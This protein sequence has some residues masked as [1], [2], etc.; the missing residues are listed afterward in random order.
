MENKVHLGRL[1]KP[2]D[3]AQRDA[4]HLAVAPVVAAIRLS[5][6]QR[7]SL[8]VDGKAAPCDRPIGIVDPFLR[9][10]VL[11]GQ[12]FYMMLLPYTITGLRHEWYHP[13]FGLNDSQK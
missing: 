4:I 8:N 12:T 5:P 6:G 3:N 13:A 10:D 2:E 11:P 7:I 9:G 1:V